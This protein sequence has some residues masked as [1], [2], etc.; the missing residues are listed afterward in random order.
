MD[1]LVDCTHCMEKNK[2][3]SLSYALYKDGLHM[4]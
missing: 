4:E 3:K 1:N 2:A